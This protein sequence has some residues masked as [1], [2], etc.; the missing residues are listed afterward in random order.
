MPN[1]PVRL[2]VA[3]D[4]VVFKNLRVWEAQPNPAWEA[5]RA[6]YEGRRPVK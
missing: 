4:G 3:G 5:N 1:R 2:T 6:K